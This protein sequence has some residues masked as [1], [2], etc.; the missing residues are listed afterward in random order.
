MMKLPER[1][2]LPDVV[3][4]P[5]LYPRKSRIPHWPIWLWLVVAMVAAIPL[6]G[7]PGVVLAHYTTSNSSFCLTCHGTGETPD[8]SVPSEIH[9]NFDKVSCVDCHAKPGQVVFE[10]YVKGFQAE[11]ERV[12]GNCVRCHPA[13]PQRTD[14]QGFKFNP[15]GIT[16][17]HSAHLERGASCVTCHSNVAHDLAE[18][19]TNRPRMEACYTCHSRSDSCAKCH[20]SNIPAPAANRELVGRKPVAPPAMPAPV[21]APPAPVA[22]PPAPVAAPSVTPVQQP[23]AGQQPAPPAAPIAVPAPPKPAVD[24]ASLEEGKSLFAKTCAGCHGP[25]GGLM[26]SAKLNSKAYLQGYGL[27]ALAQT[28]AAGKGG[29][30]PFGTAKGGPLSDQQVKAIVDYLV[31]AAN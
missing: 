21:A 20:G 12:A 24:T 3:D 2:R 14:N 7:V 30:P 29:M 22:A 8:R 6:V 1:S 13:M 15:R 31:S 16:I 28:T 26:P 19:R 10:G 27:D 17:N 18:V 25:D 23:A 4:I 5:G 11:P 9:P